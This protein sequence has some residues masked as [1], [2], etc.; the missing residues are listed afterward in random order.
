MQNLDGYVR[1]MLHCLLIHRNSQKIY[2]SFCKCV[3]KKENFL[4][5]LFYISVSTS[6]SRF[7]AS[8]SWFK[9]K[10]PSASLISLPLIPAD[11]KVTKILG[12]C[13]YSKYN[14]RRMHVILKF[15][16]ETSHLFTYLLGNHMGLK[17]RRF[18]RLDN[19]SL[20]SS[21]R[22]CYHRH[23]RT[24]CPCRDVYHLFV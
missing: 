21:S 16:I 18:R 14:T 20:R 23:L 1:Q 5:Q 24:V 15:I 2:Y 22:P 7:S 6:N 8:D 12:Q 13:H 4:D 10:L 11:N 19:A 3:E 9:N 17:V